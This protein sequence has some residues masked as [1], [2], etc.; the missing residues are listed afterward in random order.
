[1]ICS[2]QR[3][4]QRTYDL[5]CMI[6]LT[7]LKDVNIDEGIGIDLFGIETRNLKGYCEMSSMNMICDRV[8]EYREMSYCFPGGRS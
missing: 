6:E 7:L 2:V 8:V 3:E 4:F 5:C 1:M